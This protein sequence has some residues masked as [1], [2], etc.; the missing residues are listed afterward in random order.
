MKLR[1]GVVIHFRGKENKILFSKKFVMR[2]RTG[3]G[4]ISK[5]TSELKCSNS[6]ETKDR[7]EVRKKLNKRNNLFLSFSKSSGSTISMYIHCTMY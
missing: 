7:A 5:S 3:Y 2:I 1:A 6:Q 4:L